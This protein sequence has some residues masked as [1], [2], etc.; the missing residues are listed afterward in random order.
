MYFKDRSH[1]GQELAKALATYRGQQDIILLALPR[2]GV[3]VAFEIAELLDLP[4]DVL[5]V[6]KLG[7]PGQDEYAMGAIAEDGILYINQYIVQQLDIPKA[8]IENITTREIE[9]LNRRRQIYRHDRPAPQLDGKT[10]IVVDDGLATGA[11]MK[12][13]VRALRQMNVKH[14]VVAVPV[15]A[16]DTCRELEKEADEVICPYKPD[17]FYGVGRWY[18][19]FSQTSDEQLEKLLMLARKQAALNTKE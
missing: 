7:I 18:G 11:T 2:G 6:R 15:G 9:E 10:V 19:D 13:A 1:A 16:G 17:P 4:L 14:L 8:V 12:A 5:L 3:P